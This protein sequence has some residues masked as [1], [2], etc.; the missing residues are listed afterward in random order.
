MANFCWTDLSR[1]HGG[2]HRSAQ[3]EFFPCDIIIFGHLPQV[4]VLNPTVF[5]VPVNLCVLDF[6][7]LPE[8]DVAALRSC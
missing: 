4:F 7:H 1:G 8:P 5:W 6:I 2:C 3:I